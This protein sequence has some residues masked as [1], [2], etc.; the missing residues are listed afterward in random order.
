MFNSHLLSPPLS[1]LSCLFCLGNYTKW[2]KVLSHALNLWI[3]VV[4][5]AQVHKL[6]HVTMTTC[7]YICETQ[8]DSKELSEL[9]HAPVIGSHRCRKSV[10]SSLKC[11]LYYY[12]VKACR[13]ATRPMHTLHKNHQPSDFLGHC[14]T[15]CRDTELP[16]ASP[17]SDHQVCT[18][19][20]WLV[21]QSFSPAAAKEDTMEAVRVRQNS[22]VTK[23]T[24]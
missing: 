11:K 5:M 16:R 17:V 15:F 12:K 20:G 9:E 7:L 6:K 4:A 2:K 3:H 22:K 21:Y 19:A 14:Y 18:A 13:T 23:Q 10:C 8:G 1:L 24:A